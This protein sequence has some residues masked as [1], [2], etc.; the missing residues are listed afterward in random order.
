MSEWI[1][2]SER[3]PENDD[4]VLVADFD[5]HYTSCEPNYQIACYGD[6]F[7]NNYPSWDNGDG[8]GVNLKTITHWMPLPA[9]PDE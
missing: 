2:C 1:K 6:W 8:L 9:P 5:A 7:K 3:M 4:Y